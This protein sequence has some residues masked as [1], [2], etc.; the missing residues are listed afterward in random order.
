MPEIS[1]LAAVEKGAKIA[2][3]VKIGP[4]SYIGRKVQIASGCVIENNV[5]IIGKTSV[6]QKCHIFPMA[7]IGTAG[8]GASK[9]GRCILGEANTIREHVTIYCRPGDKTRIGNDNLIMIGCVIGS[10]AEIAN[11]G[12]FD[13]SSHIG[14]KA[15]VEDYVRM[16]GFATVA[17]GVTVGAYAFVTGYASVDRDAPPY[18]RVQGCPIRVRGVNTPNL[19]RCGFGDDDI[20]AIKTA[21]RELFNGSTGEVDQAVLARLAAA[22]NPHVRR[23]VEAVSRSGAGGAGK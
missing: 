12:I 6:A 19:K 9:P 11:H 18:S 1:P 23:L 14:P 21:F 3:D 13:N 16:S 10:G 5:T 17:E 7:V 8:D 2:R 4:F 22:E 20:R 15:R